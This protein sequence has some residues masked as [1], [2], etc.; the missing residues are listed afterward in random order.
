MISEIRDREFIM[1]L[2]QLSLDEKK[3]FLGIAHHFAWSNGDF[4][5]AQKSVIKG[6][7]SEMQIEDID[8]NRDDF[9]INEVLSKIQN[10][11]SQRIILLET[12]ALIYADSSNLDC[13][14]E[15]EEAIL[16][17]M[18]LKFKIE[19]DVLKLYAEWTKCVFSLSAQGEILI[20]LK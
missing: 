4:S 3:I 12:M 11:I 17:A 20:R 14:H 9:D 1:F 7:C 6:Y 18:I 13:V 8:Y 5:D 2:N 15:G 16:N 10:P 19:K